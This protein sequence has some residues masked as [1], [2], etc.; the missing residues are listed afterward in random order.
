MFDSVLIR[1][2]LTVTQRYVIHKNYIHTYMC[3]CVCVRAHYD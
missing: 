3:V 2:Y 1:Q